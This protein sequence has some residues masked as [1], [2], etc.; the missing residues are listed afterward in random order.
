MFKSRI[1]CDF[2]ARR[3]D[4]E[5]DFDRRVRKYAEGEE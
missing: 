1:F 5:E 4:A 2:L 3:R